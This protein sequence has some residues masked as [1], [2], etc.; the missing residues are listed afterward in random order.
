MKA[1]WVAWTASPLGLRL[2]QSW[3]LPLRSTGRPAL[4]AAN[5]VLAIADQALVHLAGEQGDAVEASVVAEPMAG[6]AHL[7]A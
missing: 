1:A 6:H 4:T 7:A 2:Q 3:R 5:Q